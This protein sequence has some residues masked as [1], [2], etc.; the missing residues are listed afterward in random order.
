MTR[1]KT[2]AWA[3][4]VLALVVAILLTLRDRWPTGHVTRIPVPTDSLATFARCMQWPPS[5]VRR[6]TRIPHYV[7]ADR[8]GVMQ[9]ATNAQYIWVWA[10]ADFHAVVRHEWTHIALA[11]DPKHYDLMWRD[12]LRCGATLTFADLVGGNTQ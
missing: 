9:G 10:E 12:A 7:R 8:D 1:H 5:V 6:I 2:L 4:F 11:G 3:A